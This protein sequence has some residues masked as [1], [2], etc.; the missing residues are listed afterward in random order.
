MYSVMTYWCPT[1]RV[2]IPRVNLTNIL[3]IIFI[4]SFSVIRLLSGVVLSLVRLAGRRM[5]GPAA[6][7]QGWWPLRHGV[8]GSWKT[9]GWAW[10]KGRWLR[11]QA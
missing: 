9:L 7:V 2:F 4:I 1:K 6:E 5:V 11:F 10:N 8:E 3:N